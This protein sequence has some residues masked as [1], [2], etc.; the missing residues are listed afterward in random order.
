MTNE[1]REIFAGIEKLN[2]IVRGFM[3][4]I[5]LTTAAELE[6]FTLLAQGPLSPQEVAGRLSLDQRATEILLRALA[7][8]ELLKNEAGKF[9]NSEI[10]ATFLVRGKPFYQ[11]DILCHNGNIHRRW[12][13]LPK[14]LRTGRPAE[15]PH[16]AEDSRLLRN[17]ILGM[18]DLALLSA[19]SLAVVIDIAP[20]RRLLDVGGGPGTYAIEFCRLNP[21]LTA[22]V[23]DLPAVVE[24]ITRDQVS[25]AGLADRIECIGGDYLK[26]DLGQGFDLVLV[27]SIIHSLGEAEIRLLF[28]KCRR[29]LVSGGR[30]VVKDFFLEEDRIT[31]AFASMFAVNMLSGTEAGNCYTAS[32]TRQ[33]LEEAGFSGIEY[34]Q[35][36]PRDRLLIGKASKKI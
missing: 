17:F 22:A 23:F 11:G 19:E 24:R 12:I 8:M 32:E 33:L 16:F 4:S 10:T 27:S 15:G 13:E 5:V 3:G 31:P 26:D 9:A 30:I 6:L 1:K 7:G 35:S 2:T 14:V 18:K 25:Q 29:A 21:E 28:E 20:A 36:G 34:R